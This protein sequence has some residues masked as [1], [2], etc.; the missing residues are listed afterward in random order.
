[1]NCKNCQNTLEENAHFCNNCGAKVVLQRINFKNL[2]LEFFIVNF[3][4]D[5]RFFLTMRKMVTHPQDVVK[6]YLEGVRRRYIN[7][8]AFLSVGAGLSVIIFNYFADDFMAI[9][10]TINEAQIKELKE[11]ANKDISDIKDLTEKEIQKLEIDKKVAQYQLDLMDGMWE[12]MLR[13]FNLLT[14]VFLL[15]YAILSKWTFFKPHNYGEH[16]V[17]NGYI[18]GFTTYLTLIAFFLAILIHP[19]IYMITIFGSIVYYMYAFGKIYKLS[20]GKNILK[21]FRFFV[22]L[23]I[24]FIV[25][26]ILTVLTGVFIGHMGWINFGN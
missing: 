17:I 11:K 20:I 7:P 8:F 14:F 12:F 6:E 4:V 23:I 26:L 13:Y 24:I 22:G 25:F 19:S 9:Q 15:L 5:S 16:I 18:Y 3:G 1:M 2:L 21:L 10:G